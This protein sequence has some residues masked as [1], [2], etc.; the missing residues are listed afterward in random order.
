[1]KMSYNIIMD[2][3]ILHSDLN[4]FYASVECMTRPELKDVPVAVAGSPELRHGVVLAKNAIAKAAGVKTGDVIFEAEAKCPGIVFVPPH[5]DLYMQ[6][7]RKIFSI[8]NNFT[9]Q[10]EP[11]GPDECWLDC[12]G[13]EKLFGTPT[14]I[15][16]KIRAEVK[17]QTDLTVS[18][19][20]S[21]TKPYAKMCSD[22]ADADGIYSA[23]RGEHRQ[24]LWTRPVGELLMVGRK[25]AVKLNH[26][27]IH[28]VGDLA[29]ADEG[30]L[31]SLLGVN[32]VKLRLMARGED[33]ERVREAVDKHVNE[34]V[35]HGM[36]AA[37]DIVTD[38][39]LVTVLTYLSEKIT[40][41]MIKYGVKGTCLSASIRN[42]ELKSVSR[43]RHVERPIFASQDISETAFKLIKTLWDGSPL[44]SVAISVSELC[45][46][47]SGGQLSFFDE[48]QTK[49]ETLELT[50]SKLRDKY[51]RD[52]ILRANLIERDF[53]YEKDDNEDFLPFMR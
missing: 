27:N 7:S 3:L 23:L 30:V 29:V 42:R 49:R 46:I 53:I 39:E 50:L 8:Y 36:T 48:K 37:K 1:M 18:I 13:C 40:A 38:E 25:T 5:F 20:I 6:Y 31:R 15:A 11:F 21:F 10:V 19:G 9:P 41:R 34:S 43:Q 52:S 4:N 2:R 45:P 33:G 47:D 16:E 17:K 26:I 28:T 22:L 24:K 14:E 12:T 44:R 32:G 51:G 35:G